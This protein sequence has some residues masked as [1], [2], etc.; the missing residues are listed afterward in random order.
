MLFISFVIDE[1]DSYELTWETRT[2][3]PVRLM[4]FSPDGTLFATAGMNDPLVKVWYQDKPCKFHFSFIKQKFHKQFVYKFPIYLIY[5]AVSFQEHG[6]LGGGLS[7]MYG[8][9]DAVRFR[10][11]SSPS[12]SGVH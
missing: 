4:S 3:S 6:T 12:V 2:S 5:S 7:H 9:F 1:S 11:S 8:Q 10:I